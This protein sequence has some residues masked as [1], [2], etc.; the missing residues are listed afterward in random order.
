[1]ITLLALIG[2]TG[3]A[4]TPAGDAGL[5]SS[6][7]TNPIL[8]PP[9]QDPQITFHEGR[10]YYCES[11]ADGVY[12]R[13]ADDFTGLARAE[14]HRV[15]APA[16]RGRFTKNIWAPELHILDG[17]AHIY[18]A[19][20]DGDNANHRM[21]VLVAESGDILG[22]YRLVSILE[23]QGW[24]IDGTVFTLADGRRYF[25]WSGWPGQENGQQNLYIARMKS[26]TELEGGR[27]LL[28][29]PDQGWER[30]AMPICE[31]PQVLQRE[32]RSFVVY[33]ASGSW[34]AD[35]CLGLLAFEG[36]DPLQA[37]HWT[38]GGR[39]FARN[40]FAHGVGHCAFVTSADGDDWIVYHTKT[41]PSDG[42]EDREVR[43]Q[44]FRWDSKGWP[45]FGMPVNPILPLP[46]RFG[47]TLFFAGAEAV[48][49]GAA[50]SGA[51]VN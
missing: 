43:A 19:A 51:R 28:K 6:I 48:G 21:G 13:V 5:A 44:P 12:L 14:P 38:A 34:T 10:Y 23:T 11:N 46:K 3:F 39:V 18:V 32:G 16:R 47:K 30:H 2:G 8:R 50:V 33:S 24:A 27:V 9:A 17:R 31:G 22:P 40:E 7:V 36:E 4:A 42:W 20:D 49:A 1:M 26:P 35:Y 15:W 41:E 45:V 25:I 37:G 29:Q